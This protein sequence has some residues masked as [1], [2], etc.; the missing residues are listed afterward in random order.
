MRPVPR[1]ES[2]QVYNWN[3]DVHDEGFSDED[4]DEGVLPVINLY[5]PGKVNLVLPHGFDG[6]PTKGMKEKNKRKLPKD[7]AKRLA[8]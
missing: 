2:E 8:N 1:I 5:N 4:V 3:F 6:D 7:I